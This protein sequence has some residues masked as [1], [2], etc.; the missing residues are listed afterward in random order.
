[1]LDQA[2]VNNFF[3]TDVT[4]HLKRHQYMST[5]VYS[6]YKLLD[7]IQ[8]TESVIDVGCGANLFKQFLPNLIGIDPATDEAD[9]KVS[10]QD[11]TTDQKFD[12]ALCLGSIQF[13]DIN[14]VKNQ[15]GKV[16]SLLKPHARIYWRCNPCVQPNPEWFFRWNMDHHPQFAEEFG[17]KVNELAWD[18]HDKDNPKTY[19]IYAEWIRD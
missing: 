19:R 10:I 16:V 3:S 13:G 11:Y 6:G 8:T 15:I 9:F 5:F 4:N 18:Y 2:Q 14:D 7:K 17:F 12:V 1:M